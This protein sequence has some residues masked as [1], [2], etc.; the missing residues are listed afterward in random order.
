MVYRGRRNPNRF[1]PEENDEDEE[2]IDIQNLVTAGEAARLRDAQLLAQ[3]A[4]RMAKE[5][6]EALQRL[7]EFRTRLGLPD[8]SG[9]VVVGNDASTSREGDDSCRC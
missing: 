7:K 9:N 3:E 1:N 2:E 4:L 6:R 8:Y 5:A